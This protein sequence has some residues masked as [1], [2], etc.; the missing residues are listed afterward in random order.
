[1]SINI[2]KD[3]VSGLVAP[4]A[5]AYAKKQDRKINETNARAKI[6]Q[7]KQSGEKEVTLKD[8]EWEAVNADKANTTWKDEFVTILIMSPFILVICG[9][10]E[11]LWRGEA[12]QIIPAVNT[13][14]T[15]LK[16]INVD[17]GFLMNAV[18]LSA[19]GL[20]IWRA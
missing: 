3:V 10:V 8:A 17:L 5:N 19:L 4:V 20:K 16:E 1:M 12:H 14:Y 11:I 13:M 7:A 6:A 2:V 18:V 15:A 9:V